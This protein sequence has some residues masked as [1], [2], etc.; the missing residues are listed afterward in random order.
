MRMNHSN[1]FK[2]SRT[3][4]DFAEGEA[5]RKQC[6]DGFYKASKGADR[7]VHPNVLLSRLESEVASH[8]GDI[9]SV[10]RQWTCSLASS[11]LLDN[12]HMPPLIVNI[13]YGALAEQNGWHLK[14]VLREVQRVHWMKSQNMSHCSRDLGSFLLD[15]FDTK[16]MLVV[17]KGQCEKW[18]SEAHGHRHQK[19][20]IAKYSGCRHQQYEY[21]P[22]MQ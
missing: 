19:L 14:A 17:T 21:G 13:T 16:I 10:L 5:A 7:L 20:R 22:L 4:C 12:L 6:C 9:W 11:L 3:C 1:S 18:Q 15:L 8:F 2:V